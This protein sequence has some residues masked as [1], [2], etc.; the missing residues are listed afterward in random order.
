MNLITIGSNILNM[1]L[2][3]VWRFYTIEWGNYQTVKETEN[4]PEQKEKISI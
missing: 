4:S 1:W 3:S 2:T